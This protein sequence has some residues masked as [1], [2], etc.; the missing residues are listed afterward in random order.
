MG[1]LIREGAHRNQM[2]RHPFILRLFRRGHARLAIRVWV[3]NG[4]C[5][6]GNHMTFSGHQILLR[7]TTVHV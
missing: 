3:R 5:Q 1:R 7:N 6:N 2:V 4:R